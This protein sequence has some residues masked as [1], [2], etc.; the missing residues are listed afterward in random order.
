M[1]ADSSVRLT[2][3]ARAYCGLAERLT[4]LRRNVA[5]DCPRETHGLNHYKCHQTHVGDDILSP[6]IPETEWCAR[7]RV[8]AAQWDEYRSVRRLKVAAER[9]MRYAW[10]STREDEKPTDGDS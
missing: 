7:C 1:R 2:N 6:I 4:V 8:F 9:R 3:A 5:G 10:R